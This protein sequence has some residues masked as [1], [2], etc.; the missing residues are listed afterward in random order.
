MHD[1]GLKTSIQ[2]FDIFVRCTL[3]GNQPW[4][5]FQNGIWER[6]CTFS[7]S[8]QDFN[9]TY[10]FGYHCSLSTVRACASAYLHMSRT[11]SVCF[12][13][14]K[15]QPA[16]RSKLTRL[17]LSLT[18]M[19]LTRSGP[20]VSKLA[21]EMGRTVCILMFLTTYGSVTAHTTRYQLRITISFRGKRSDQTYWTL[22]YM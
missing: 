14:T 4:P 12:S 13:I 21:C 22:K 1:L 5:Q 8:F 17:N 20:S 11:V 18:Q 6:S 19:L 16:S 15:I 3:M 9:I 10:S 2:T 7:I